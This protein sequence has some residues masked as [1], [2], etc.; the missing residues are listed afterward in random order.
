MLWREI[1]HIRLAISNPAQH[2]IANCIHPVKHT[3]YMK[4]KDAVDELGARVTHE[5][6]ARNLGVSVAS[7][8]QYRLDPDANAHRTPPASWRRVLAK[9]ARSR[10]KELDALANRLDL[11]E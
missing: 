11:S 5:E 1:R 7:V 9:L 4:F 8:R 3:A 10:A 6:V 2:S